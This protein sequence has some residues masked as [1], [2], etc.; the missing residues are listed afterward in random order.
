VIGRYQATLAKVQV[1]YGDAVV[2][3]EER[4]VQHL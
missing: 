4:E 3:F 2:V 1:G